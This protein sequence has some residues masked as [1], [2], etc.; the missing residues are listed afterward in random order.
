MQNYLALKQRKVD[1][2]LGQVEIW[3]SVE[4]SVHMQTSDYQG[5][6]A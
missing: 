3:N 2:M 4:F 6:A 5:S 1:C